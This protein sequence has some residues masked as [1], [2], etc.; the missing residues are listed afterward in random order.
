MELRVASVGRRNGTPLSIMG[1]L[2]YFGTIS[3]AY[4]VVG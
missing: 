2:A 3:F 4:N 1:A